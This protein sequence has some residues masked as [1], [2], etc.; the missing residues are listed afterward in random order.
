MFLYSSLIYFVRYFT[1][2]RI[3]FFLLCVFLFLCSVRLRSASCP[4]PRIF[5]KNAAVPT[6]VRVS[7]GRRVALRCRTPSSAVLVVSPSTRAPFPF[8]FDYSSPSCVHT[9]HALRRHT[10]ARGIVK[11]RDKRVLFYFFIFLRPRH[12]FV[13]YAN[14]SRVLSAVFPL[15]SRLNFSSTW[16]ANRRRRR[17]RS[18]RTT[19]RHVGVFREERIASFAAVAF[20]HSPENNASL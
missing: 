7:F 20:R 2:S 16:A 13:V 18:R 11:I 4:C 14:R 19:V 9:S 5:H 3:S 17:R 15:L 10:V 12:F 1:K 6:A 8:P